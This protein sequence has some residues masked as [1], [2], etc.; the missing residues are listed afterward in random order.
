MPETEP[1]TDWVTVCTTDRVI[2]DAG[3]CAL[4]GDTQ[5]AVFHVISRDE[6]YAVQNRCPHWNEMVLSRA[7]TGE[8]DGEPHIACPMHK[9]TFAL[10]TGD[11]LTG[12]V[13]NLSTFPIRVVGNEVQV[14][15]PIDGER[16]ATANGLR[17]AVGE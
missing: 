17:T 13:G 16:C 6:W 10:A 4:L 15:A 8:T 1:T 2:G 3:V 14:A 5:I 9:K 11:C 12:D 7:L